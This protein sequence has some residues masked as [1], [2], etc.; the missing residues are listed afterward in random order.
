[1]GDDRRG[2]K[3]QRTESGNELCR[4]YNKGTCFRGSR[5]ALLLFTLIQFWVNVCALDASLLI[6]RMRTW[7]EKGFHSAKTF[8]ILRAG[9]GIVCMYTR[10]S[11]WRRSTWAQVS[12]DTLQHTCYVQLCSNWNYVCNISRHVSRPRVW[13]LCSAALLCHISGWVPRFVLKHCLERFNLC[14]QFMK[15][16]TLAGAWWQRRQEEQL[17]I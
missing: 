2:S 3:R 4:D 13:I 16:L 8:G 12:Q 7:K 11:F 17:Q 6:P 10:Q 1:M 15:V 5:W 14:I 9:S